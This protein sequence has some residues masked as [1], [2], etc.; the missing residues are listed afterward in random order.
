MK[1]GYAF[2]DP[3]GYLQTRTWEYIHNDNPGFWQDNAAFVLRVWPFDQ[4][5]LSSMYKMF[6]SFRDL[7]MKSA[8]VQ[9]F[10]RSINFDIAELRKYAGSVQSD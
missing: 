4:D 6:S 7:Q 1:K 2:L 8:I 5:D 9:E 3:D 10:A